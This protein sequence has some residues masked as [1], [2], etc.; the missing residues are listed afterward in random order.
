ML[1]DSNNQH[2]G[3]PLDHEGNSGRSE[4]PLLQKNLAISIDNQHNRIKPHIN[5]NS[6][7]I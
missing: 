2:I 4:D 1:N 3:G 6:N 7:R 5:R